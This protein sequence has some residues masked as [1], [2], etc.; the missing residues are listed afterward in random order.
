MDV[1]AQEATYEIQFGNIK[2]PTHSNT[3]WDFARFEVS[4]HKW[5]DLSEGGYGV[6]ILN[7]CKY[8]YD[9]QGNVLGLSL[10]KSAIRPD[11]TADRKVH[12]F[13][14]SLYPHAGMLKEADVQKEAVFLNMPVLTEVVKGNEKAD[15]SFVSYGLV[16]CD[17]E[18]VLI[19]TI[20]Q[21]EDGKALIVRVY[22]Y[23]NRKDHDCKLVFHV[24]VSRVCECNLCEENEVPV[25]SEND[26]VSFAIGCY[27]VKSFKVYMK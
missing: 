24:P 9:V 18:H 20:K 4:G 22:E 15:S 6:A 25:E 13:T 11:E 27:E 8:G 16:S 21:S 23:Q 26:A 10:I 14:Y 7:D 2:R 1:H 17:S 19:D 3:E 12:Y 5:V